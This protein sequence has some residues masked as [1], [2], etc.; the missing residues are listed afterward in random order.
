MMK[1]YFY[2]G[3]SALVNGANTVFCG[4]YSAEAEKSAG[5]VILEIVEM[6]KLEFKEDNIVLTAF[7]LI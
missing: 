5:D 7:N 4:T 3:Q 6:K 2:S 1:N